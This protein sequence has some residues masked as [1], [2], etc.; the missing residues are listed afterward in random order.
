MLSD[1]LVGWL[2]CTMDRSDADSCRPFIIKLHR[3]HSKY[4]QMRLARQRIGGDAEKGPERL[5]IGS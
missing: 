5:W 1:P 2:F 4:E 3:I